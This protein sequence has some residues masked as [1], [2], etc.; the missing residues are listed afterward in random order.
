[1]YSVNGIHRFWM[2]RGGIACEFISLAI[3]IQ[4]SMKKITIVVVVHDCLSVLKVYMAMVDRLFDLSPNIRMVLIDNGSPEDIQA[5]LAQQAHPAR[6]VIRFPENI[7]KAHAV[8]QLMRNQ[9]ELFEGTEVLVSMDPDIIFPVSSFEYL[10]QATVDIPNAG[11]LGM[12]FEKNQ[13]NPERNVWFPARSRK[14]KSGEIYKIYKAFMMNV[15]GGLFAVPWERVQTVLGGVLYPVLENRV[16]FPD[17]WYLYDFLNRKGFVVGYLK[18]T[19]VS[20]L[21]SGNTYLV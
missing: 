1:M 19:T 2:K 14:G 20:H 8:N 6:T 18:G 16:Y 5:Y 4:L 11:M 13:C 7:G 3:T 15:P 9:P 17:D 10:V 21:K 12:R